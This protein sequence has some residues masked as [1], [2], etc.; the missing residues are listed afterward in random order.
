MRW[1]DDDQRELDAYLESARREAAWTFW[2][3]AGFC[4]ALF[5]VGCLAACAIEWVIQ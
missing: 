5:A 1:T 4:L 2:S 3:A